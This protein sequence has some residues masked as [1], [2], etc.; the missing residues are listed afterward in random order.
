MMTIPWKSTNSP[1]A[2]TLIQVSR[3]ELSHARDVPG[4]LIAAMR[5]RRAT[6]NAP[7]AVGLSLRAAPLSRTFWT[8]SSWA[9][10]EAI[11][12][13]VVSDVHIA[14]MN[15]YRDRMA[16]SHFHTWTET[17]PTTQPPCWGDAMHRYD[18][19]VQPES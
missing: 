17:E 13:F 19:T 10:Q 1:D 9:D 7:G 11:T 4:F 12:A 14:V 15:R 5:I 16:G 8:L 3:L 2:A 6:L 18:S